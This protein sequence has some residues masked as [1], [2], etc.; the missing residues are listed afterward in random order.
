M[1]PRARSDSSA[2]RG[3][4]DA[5]TRLRL[6]LWT[7]FSIFSMSAFAFG[8]RPFFTQANDFPSS[9]ES[10]VSGIEAA[11]FKDR[12]AVGKLSDEPSL[13]SPVVIK[14]SV[15]SSIV[16]ASVKCQALS[17][18]GKILSICLGSFTDHWLGFEHLVFLYDV[19]SGKE[20][21]RLAGAER[22]RV[23]SF[24]FSP[25]AKRLLIYVSGN[26]LCLWDIQTEKQIVDFRITIGG[27]FTFSRDGS[28]LLGVSRIDESQGEIHMW[29]AN[30]G[31]LVRH[32]GSE[33]GRVCSY[34][35]S[36]DEKTLLAVHWHY[37]IRPGDGK[38]DGNFSE[39]VSAHLWDVATG[40]HLGKVGSDTEIPYFG[41]DS[42]LT[43]L[44]EVGGEAAGFRVRVSPSGKILLFPSWRNLP[45]I[46]PEQ[47]FYVRPG[48][49][50]PSLD[51]KKREEDAALLSLLKY[52]W[53]LRSAVLSL[54]RKTLI[55]N[56]W[57]VIGEGKKEK[58]LPL[59][60]IQDVSST[61]RPKSAPRPVLQA[62]LESWWRD[63][64][65]PDVSQAYP[66]V[67][68]MAEVPRDVLAFIRKRV[69]PAAARDPMRLAQLVADL[70][71]DRYGVRE[72]AERELASWG[73]AAVPALRK[74][75][76]DPPSVEARTRME[77]L[78]DQAKSSALSPET[79]QGLW[80][81][82]LLEHLATP[83]ARELLKVLSR[84]DSAGWVTRE[85][86]A[87]LERLAQPVGK[88]P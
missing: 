16:S 23:N 34:R 35:L 68:A 57:Q 26:S 72:R 41:S 18:D 40:K 45:P 36:G 21:A 1:N 79:L 73:E 46:S 24:V 42:V 56:G 2:F 80:T 6:L 25:D 4:W 44:G 48:Q 43:K 65:S 66:A 14:L 11:A 75:L 29:D 12:P 52:D 69:R 83:E 31:K 58:R 76:K 9:N 59:I 50:F 5:Q 38:R 13:P 81:V 27:E 77:R 10:R 85:A 86:K 47:G 8:A 82:E 63:L 17:P 61:V 37:P 84:G 54:D 22:T 32:F 49:R 88:N 39:T 78:L 33:Y 28:V 60:L 20:I 15:P 53:K 74:A 19:K 64:A 51:P 55:A 7:A 3:T 62:E 70:D 87:S 30:S 67:R 71:A